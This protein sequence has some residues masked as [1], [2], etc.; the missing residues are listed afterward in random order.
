MDKHLL[1]TV[2]PQVDAG[3]LLL[4]LAASALLLYVHG[5]PKAMHYAQQLALIEDPF[6]LGPAFSLWFAI[7]AEVICPVLIILGVLARLACLPIIVVMLVALIFVHPGW[8]IADGQFA[9]LL[10]II[11]TTLAIGG[12]G[13]WTLWAT[14]QA[15]YERGGTR[16]PP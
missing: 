1:P 2:A 16:P 11:F 9:W 10:L 3:L 7:F 8:S 6:G 12:P 5:L 14:R 4:R 15:R 13:R